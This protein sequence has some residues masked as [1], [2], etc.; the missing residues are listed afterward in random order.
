MPVRDEGPESSDDIGFT[1][2]SP[3]VLS[4]V[5]FVL[6]LPA[7]FFFIEFVPSAL[8]LPRLSHLTA[9]A[10]FIGGILSVLTAPLAL[11]LWSIALVRGGSEYAF[12]GVW[13]AMTWL[14]AFAAFGRFSYWW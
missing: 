2:I 1:V 8:G 5:C 13:V 12:A 4:G 7:L 9:T 14:G 10:Y 6:A 3:R 11:L